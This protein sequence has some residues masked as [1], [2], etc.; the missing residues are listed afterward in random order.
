MRILAGADGDEGDGDD[1]DGDDADDNEGDGDGVGDGDH[2]TRSTETSRLATSTLASKLQQ[3]QSLPSAERFPWK[4]LLLPKRGSLKRGSLKRGS[5]KR[6]SLKR[7]SLI[8][9]P[10]QPLKQAL[11]QAFNRQ[12]A[13]MQTRS[14]SVYSTSIRAKTAGSKDEYWA[15]SGRQPYTVPYAH[16]HISMN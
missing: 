15:I 3:T 12:R 14:N 13:L 10:N 4:T 9:A 11:E 5:L 1:G 16:A 8:Q 2:C 7:C 6:G